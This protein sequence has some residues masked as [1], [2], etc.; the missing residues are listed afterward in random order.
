MIQCLL[1]I[2]VI[3]LRQM[4]HCMSWIGT[5]EGI[6][7]WCEIIKGLYTNRLTIISQSLVWPV[8]AIA[9]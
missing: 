1:S 9:L 4:D 6:V 7:Y 3:P 8:R 2:A 5:I